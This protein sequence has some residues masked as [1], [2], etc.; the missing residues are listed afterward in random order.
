MKEFFGFVSTV[1]VIGGIIFLVTRPSVRTAIDTFDFSKIR[2]SVS[3][4][5]HSDPTSDG[6]P[7]ADFSG[8]MEKYVCRTALEAYDLKDPSRKIGSFQPGTTLEILKVNRDQGLV[9]VRYTPPQGQPM[10]AYCQAAEIDV[11]VW[12]RSESSVNDQDIERMAKCYGG[13]LGVEYILEWVIPRYP[14]LASRAVEMQ[15]R[16]RTTCDPILREFGRIINLQGPDVI[17]RYNRV[18]DEAYV[19]VRNILSER[20]PPSRQAF[21]DLVF[22]LLEKEIDRI[23]E[24]AKQLKSKLK[25]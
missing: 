23:A 17:R 20:S 24:E 4:S 13:Y 15:Q 8:K 12:K 25:T 18:K 22:P 10:E 9:H 14:V 3:G 6:E 11:I 7:W 1:L 21:E 2:E 16:L 5:F 19:I